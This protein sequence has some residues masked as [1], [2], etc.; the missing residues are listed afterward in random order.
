[1]QY[2]A[3]ISRREDMRWIGEDRF[4]EDNLLANPFPEV[5]QW[6]AIALGRIQS[7]QALPLLYKALHTG[8]AAVRAASAFAIGQIEDRKILEE[9]SL[10]PDPQASVE[11]IRLLD[12]SSII[13]RMR[14]IEALGETGSHGEAAEIIRRIEHLT[15]S[16][17]PVERAYM[18]SAVAAL[19]R[20]KDPIAIPALETL[21]AAG[22]S[23]IQWR[24]LDALAQLRSRDSE[25]LFVKQLQNPNPEVQSVAA[26]GLG[27]TGGLDNAVLLLPLLAPRGSDAAKINPLKVRLCALHALG[28]LKDPEA[29]PFIQTAIASEP[30]DSA[31]PDQRSF[32]VQAAVEVGNIGAREGEDVLIPLLNSPGPAANNA[33]IALAKIHREN[34]KRFFQVIDGSGFNRR[35][36]GAAWA[37]AM[38]ELGGADA[39]HELSRMLARAMG[40]INVPEREI[41]DD[42]LSALA[43]IGT[44]ESQEILTQ[45]LSSR[46][47]ALLSA[48]VAAYRPKIDTEAPWAPVARAF[49]ACETSSDI[50]AKIRILS[51]LKP[52]IKEPE[53]QKT[54]WTG[55]KDGERSVRLIS[56][57]LLR[58]AGVAGIAEN[59]GLQN[60]AISKD[61]GYALAAYRKN[62]TI[63]RI[64]TT[65][66][67]IEISLF[68]EDAPVTSERFATLANEGIYDGMEFSLPAPF[69]AIE[70]EIPGNRIKLRRIINSEINMRPFERGSV[71][72]KLASGGSDTGGFFIAFAPQPYLDGVN[73]CFG[74]VISGM[75]VADRLVPGDRIRRITIVETV[76]FHDYQRYK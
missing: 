42:I 75:Q 44:P 63:A 4:F 69:Q 15:G 71:G 74:R 25:P 2:F 5:R 28:T 33:V 66:G 17:S 47:C 23:D 36:A 65:R 32:A 54:L 61:V 73:T 59:P 10:P 46:D 53:V 62:I 14:A 76:N 3:E 24:A 7:P 52:W 19:A 67:T 40:S 49:A 8:D 34:P 12:D 58:Q 45:I 70:G 50:G 68:R 22:D 11:L 64:E 51:S 20:L 27:V 26:C 72:M 16:G 38:A 48:A 41:L 39:V 60:S 55:T 30:L 35:D 56:A 29:I 1:V 6:C 13:V 9:T 21:A 37:S 31:H 18:E 57:G 43:G